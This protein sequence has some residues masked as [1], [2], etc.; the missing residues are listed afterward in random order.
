MCRD[1]KVYM[2]YTIGGPKNEEASLINKADICLHSSL[3]WYRQ[4]HIWTM[5]LFSIQFNKYNCMIKQPWYGKQI[6]Y[7]KIV[8]SQS[9]QIR[10]LSE[11]N[12]AVRSSSSRVSFNVRLKGPLC[13]FFRLMRMENAYLHCSYRGWEGTCG[14][15]GRLPVTQD[16]SLGFRGCDWELEWSVE[17][18]LLLI[19]SVHNF[20]T[21]DNQKARVTQV[22]CV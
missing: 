5:L 19:W 10:C 4:W 6:L 11:F 9:C 21:P 2:M 13:A 12:L 20:T 7:S 17:V 3:I 16:N 14:W 22:C 1:R 15:E 8:F 18:M